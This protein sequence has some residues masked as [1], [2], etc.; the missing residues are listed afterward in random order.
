MIGLVEAVDVRH[1]V[2]FLALMRKCLWNKNF[3]FFKQF[4]L[5]MSTI[6]WMVIISSTKDLSYMFLKLK[7]SHT[8]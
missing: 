8:Q 7:I 3:S 1:R 2:W 4:L 6:K 5:I